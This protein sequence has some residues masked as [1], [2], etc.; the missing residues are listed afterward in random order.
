[1]SRRLLVVGDDL[2]WVLEAAEAAGFEVV[3]RDGDLVLSHG[4]DGT[5]L[6]A[7][8]RHPGL[9]LVPVRHSAT[10]RACPA[11][12]LNQVLTRLAAD[13]LAQEALAQIE[14]SVGRARF[15]A[16]N[17]VVLRNENPALAVRFR[18][19]VDGSAP[20]DCAG[21]GLVVAT[22]FGSTGYFRSITRSRFERG[23]GLA[24]NNSTVSR[25]S[26]V[27]PADAHL[28]VEMVRGPALL[29]HDNDPR[30]IVL[31]E[32]HHFGVRLAESHV[33][34]LGLDSLRCQRCRRRDDGRFNPH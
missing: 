6:R 23:L 31:R 4:G 25:E 29:V 30:T 21:D 15:L 2:P 11:H 28:D 5:L 33:R 20:D 22:P 27:L 10:T 19:S 34:V 9:P 13:Q 17:D 14:L 8:R 16:L 24:F 12:E 1:M 18:L 32:G 7:V 3:T 26:R